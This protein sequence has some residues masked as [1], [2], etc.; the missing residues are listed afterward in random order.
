[1]FNEVWQREHTACER[2]ARHVRAADDRHRQAQGDQ[3]GLRAR[4]RQQRTSSWWRSACNE[5]FAA[6]DHAAR[7]GGDEFA[8][9]LP[10]ASPE[11]AEA[12]IKR[13]RHNVFK[14][15]LDL[16]SRMIRCNVSIGAVSYPKDA[17]ARCAICRAW[18]MITCIA[19]RNCVECPARK[20]THEYFPAN[21]LN[22][23]DFRKNTGKVSA[24]SRRGVLYIW[25]ATFIP[26][27][28]R[29]LMRSIIRASFLPIGGFPCAHSLG[30]CSDFSPCRR[31]PRR[32]ARKAQALLN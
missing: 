4:G 20:Q 22:V 19:T 9:L 12:V 27:L 32:L 3:R 25:S 30:F 17:Q 18:P 21:D 8:V 26:H 31:T 16:R 29:G 13:I 5:A 10:G 1:M 6:R 28:E 11:V 15:T 2:S 7:F 23:L 24:A 14:T